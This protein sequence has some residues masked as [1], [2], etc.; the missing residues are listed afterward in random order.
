MISNIPELANFLE[1]S[2]KQFCEVAVIGT[3]GGVDSSV[4]AA[5]A[6][7]ALGIENVYLVSMPYD[8]VD[9]KSFNAR[10]SELANKLGAHH[11]V[12]SIHAATNAIENELKTSHEF[13]SLALLTKANIRP[14]MRMSFLYAISG[15]L[16]ARTDNLNKR[17]RVLGTGHL[18]EDLIGYDTKGGDA[19]ADIFILSDLLKSEVYQLANYYQIPTSII[20]APPSAGL[21]QGQTDYAELGYSYEELEA[22]T[23]ALHLLIKKGLQDSEINPTNSAFN[24]MDQEIVQFVVKRFKANSHK[25][26]APTTLDCRRPEWFA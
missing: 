2:L 16:S 10:S 21:Y 26:R 13:G 22:S 6:C 15:E 18:S 5:I 19:L 25:H 1:S 8:D 17:V 12:L 3:S 23:L 7:K 4:V 9:R 20:Q 14:R 24:G 11:L